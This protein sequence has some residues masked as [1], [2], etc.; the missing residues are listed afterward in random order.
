M[1]KC[2]CLWDTALS[3]LKG[4]GSALVVAVGVAITISE[5]LLSNSHKPT[6]LRHEPHGALHC[7]TGRLA[8]GGFA[9]SQRTHADHEHIKLLGSSVAVQV[10]C[11]SGSSSMHATGD[12]GQRRLGRRRVEKRRI[13]ATCH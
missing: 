13:H 7:E 6:L 3:S 5:A 10:S 11:S 12:L 8:A 2:T 1:L 4:S 9:D